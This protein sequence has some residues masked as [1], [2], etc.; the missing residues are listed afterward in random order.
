MKKNAYVIFLIG[1]L[2]A[3]N[4]CNESDL[5]DS[6]L[7]KSNDCDGALIESAESWFNENPDKN[8][9]SLFGYLDDLKWNQAIV[10]DVDTAM[11]IE[12]PFKLKTNIETR[13]K[14]QD[15]LNVTQ[16]LLIVYEENQFSSLLEVIVSGDS[17]ENLEN[18]E[19]IN[20]TYQKYGFE[21]EFLFINSS[22]KIVKVKKVVSKDV[23]VEIK[24]KSVQVRCVVLVHLWDDGTYDIV[25]VLYCYELD[26]G[27]SSSGGTS[28]TPSDV[29]P[30][31]CDCDIC[32]VCGKCIALKSIPIP[33]E[34]DDEEETE[35]LCPMCSCPAP[36]VVDITGLE[37]NAK[38]DCIYDKLIS[39]S[40]INS[41]MKRYFGLTEPIHSFL[42]ELDLHWVVED[43]SQY[44]SAGKEILG[45]TFPIGTPSNP[46]YFVKI[47]IDSNHIQ[48]HG[49]SS[50]AY[51]MLHEAAH[52]K[53]IAEYY[54]DLGTTDFQELFIEHKNLYG[55][56]AQHREMALWE[57]V[58]Q[59]ATGVRD[60]DELI[61][62]NRDITFYQKAIY[63]QL[64]NQIVGSSTDEGE[65]EY[66]QL[67]DNS[68][69]NCPE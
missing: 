15:Q 5:D 18:M 41:F 17:K 3:I 42:G 27:T 30:D 60:F 34:G 8:K 61:G 56:D 45:N 13:I 11:L 20:C 12:V 39:G 54:D 44:T 43:L 24:L 29:D 62:V 22:G 37:Q 53:L 51:S 55:A 23:S 1:M 47:S 65:T 68:P 2:L 48:Q 69:K 28:S 46:N 9:Y 36:P 58:N 33:G 7:L 59:L 63:Y 50:I 14:G 52:A 32:Q 10:H 26:L 4:S 67:F 19:K 16:R 40:I 66:N 25:S 21:G 57:Y 49:I 6:V 31:D 64:T 38:A 35:F